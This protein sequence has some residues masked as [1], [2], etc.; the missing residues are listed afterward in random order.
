MTQRLILDDPNTAR[1]VLTFA[2][3]AAHAVEGEVRLQASR[4]VLVLTTAVLSPQGLLDQTPT[5]LG[6]RIVSCDPELICDIVI[7]AS[8]LSASD[9]PSSLLLPD[10]GRLPAW[11]GVAPPQAG[12]ERGDTVNTSRV[13]R[14]AKWGASAVARALPTDPGEDIVRTVRAQIWGEPDEELADLPR[15]VA[16][17]ADVLGFVSGEESAQL[18]HA[19]RWTRLSF[20]RGHVLVRGPVR[21]GLTEVRHTGAAQRAG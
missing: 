14:Q 16:F 17:A 4:G 6:M 12:W 21:S 7:G 11:A 2:Q 3:R 13:S 15:G 1:D 10:E 18:F 8:E 5:I 20:R 19:A 9:D